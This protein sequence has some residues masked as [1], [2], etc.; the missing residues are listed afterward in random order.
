ML[1]RCNKPHHKGFGRSQS[2][3]RQL[4]SR[5]TPHTMR[6][7]AS[8]S[9][10][11]R[12]EIFRCVI[13]MEPRCTTIITVLAEFDTLTSPHTRKQKQLD[14]AAENSII[15]KPKLSPCDVKVSAKLI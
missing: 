5:H 4:D 12:N 1:S 8:T 15:A 2:S 11:E 3:P 14:S 10:K 6:L 9:G 13:E 7:S